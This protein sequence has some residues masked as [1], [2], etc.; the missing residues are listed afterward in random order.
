VIDDEVHQQE[1]QTYREETNKVK[2]N[3]V[4]NN[5]LTLE[6]LFDL[7]SKFRRP[8]NKKTNNSSMIH[9]LVNLVTSEQPKYVNLGTCCLDL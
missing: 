9:F 6:T 8:T 3:C 5:I 7:K 2:T 1:L 4:T